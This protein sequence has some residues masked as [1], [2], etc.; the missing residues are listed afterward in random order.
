MLQSLSQDAECERLNLR[1]G[2][3]LTSAVAEHAREVRDF[4]DPAAV[5]LA[6]KLDLEGHEE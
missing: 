4:G 1:H 2:H 6:F 5:L 3:T